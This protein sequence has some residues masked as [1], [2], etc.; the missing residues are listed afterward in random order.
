MDIYGK[1]QVNENWLLP[2]NINKNVVKLGHHTWD[3]V[4]LWY[5]FLQL[6]NG[7]EDER[8]NFPY[9]PNW[10]DILLGINSRNDAHG[11]FNSLTRGGRGS[12][13]KI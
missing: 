1:I 5:L 2:W 13:F 9:Y 4:Y 12:N 6:Q 8:L 11:V 10:Y 7:L 3:T